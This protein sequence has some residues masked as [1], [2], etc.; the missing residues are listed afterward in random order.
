VSTSDHPSS[1]CPHASSTS[2]PRCSPMRGHLP[3][4]PRR[5]P[6]L[7]RPRDGGVAADEE[8]LRRTQATSSPR[9]RRPTATTGR[10]SRGACSPSS[11]PTV[12]RASPPGDH[13]LDIN[14]LA[15]TVPGH[16]LARRAPGLRD[17]R[18]GLGPA[19]PPRDDR[20]R[21]S[22]AGGS[23]ST[24]AA[25]RA[26]WSRSA[27]SRRSPSSCAR[28]SSRTAPTSRRS[29]R[30]P[31]R[32]RTSPHAATRRVR[33]SPTPASDRAPARGGLP[34]RR[35]ARGRRR[36]RALPPQLAPLPRHRPRPRGD[37]RLGLG[38]HRAAAR[39]CA[40]GRPPHRPVDRPR[41]GP[42]AAA[43]RPEP[44]RR[45]PRTRSATRC[46]SGRRSRSRSSPTCTSTSR[47]RS[48]GSR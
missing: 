27:R 31:P 17:G 32:T 3:R 25:G 9:C 41:R 10:R 45:R 21:R 37:L 35:A 42:R 7:G 13:Y 16:A 44:T 40:R 12:S 2:V 5:R 18:A 28:V 46:R 23:G 1:P 38:A 6:P 43:H 33:P 36:P 15:S 47:S 34:P 29:T 22:T 26:G 48:A 20:R 24:R 30:S 14:H 8:L 19:D 11:S 39:P 4:C